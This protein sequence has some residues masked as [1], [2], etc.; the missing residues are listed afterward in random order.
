MRIRERLKDSLKISEFTRS[1]MKNH[2]GMTG[3]EELF[4]SYKSFYFS[5]AVAIAASGIYGLKFLGH[6]I[7]ICSFSSY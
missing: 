2:S 6:L 4:F 5:P 1:C 3:W 7:L